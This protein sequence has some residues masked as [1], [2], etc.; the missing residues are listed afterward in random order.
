MQDVLWIDDQIEDYTEFVAGLKNHDI[1]ITGAPSVDNAIEILKHKSFDLILLDLRMPEKNGFEFLRSQ[2][3]KSDAP[4]CV[5]SSYLHL[6]EY[7]KRLNRLRKNVAIMDK[8]LPPPNSP[9]FSYFADRIKQFISNPP[10]QAPKSFETEMTDKFSDI[11][12][13]EISFRRYLNLPSRLKRFLRERARLIARDAINREFK[14]GAGWVLICGDPKKAEMS[15]DA[16][17]TPPDNDEVRQRAIELDRVPYQFS[18]P[19]QIDD[20]HSGACVGPS[21]IKDYPT[22]TIGIDG[23][24]LDVHF[25][26]G[27]PYTFVSFE[28]FNEFGVLRDDLLPIDGARGMNSYEYVS[29]NIRT[30]I[31]DQKK[32][33][34]KAITVQVRAVKNWNRCPFIVIC[35]QSCENFSLNHEKICMNRAAL[36]GRNLIYEN[37]LSIS[38][39]GI[40]NKSS[41]SKVKKK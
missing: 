39:C 7:Q 8:D 24:K 38:L 27:S 18:S 10:G 15:A 2:I 3:S 32:G 23:K 6:E 17:T 33:S 34:S 40:T 13:F 22:V 36:F 41:I 19:Q 37:E 25:D 35:P 28:E 21:G 29:D 20:M 26:T 14:S 12:P 9:S 1:S 4:I 16:G 5:L 30:V 31:I 11:D